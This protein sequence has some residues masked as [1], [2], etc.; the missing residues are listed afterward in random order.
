VRLFPFFTYFGGKYRAATRYPPPQ[1]GII[2]EPFAGSAGYALRYPDRQVHLVDKSE[3]IAGI[4]DYLIRTPAAEIRRLPLLE[5]GA[6]VD[7]LDV[8]QEAR[9]LLGMW[10]NPGSAQPKKTRGTWCHSDG[11]ERQ[12]QF[13]GDGVRERIAQQVDAIRH[14]RITCGDYTEAPDV[15]ATWF[16][17]PPYQGMGKHYPCGADEIDFPALG[18]W[19]RTRRGQ[20]IVCEQAGADWLPFGSFGAFKSNQAHSGRTRTAEALWLNDYPGA[21]LWL[22]GGAQ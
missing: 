12:F 11:Y 20:V 21:A 22:P 4:W 2:V 1:H 14:W 13:W 15:D 8:P 6:S 9:W 3:P 16:I 18:A 7:T 10:V 17:D 19:C 5:P